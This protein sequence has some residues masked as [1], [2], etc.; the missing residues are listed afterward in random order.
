MGIRILLA[1]LCIIYLYILQCKCSFFA[2]LKNLQKW[3][4]TVFINNDIFL[5]STTR[6][7]GFPRI[8]AW[9]TILLFYRTQHNRLVCSS[10][11]ASTPNKRS[12]KVW[13]VWTSFKMFF[14][15][16]LPNKIVRVLSE[17]F[18]KYF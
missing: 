11:G 5:K 8:T 4:T 12:L 17:H 14:V 9:N 2:P 1:F 13:S 15:C 10:K 16:N 7:A 6:I 18:N 3:T